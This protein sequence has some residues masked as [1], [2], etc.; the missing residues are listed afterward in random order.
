MS[1]PVSLHVN[2]YGTV[3]NLTIQDQDGDTVNI[4]TSSG[5]ILTFYMP[6]QTTFNRTPTIPN[7]GTDGL[8]RYTLQSGD[9][10]IPGIYSLQANIVSSSGVWYS[11]CQEF[12]VERNI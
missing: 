10:T 12:R 7:G 1:D 4:S 2:D 11:N 8:L 6:D 5:N 3:F 9:I